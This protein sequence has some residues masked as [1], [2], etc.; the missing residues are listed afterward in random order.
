MVKKIVT[1]ILLE[2]LVITCLKSTGISALV[3][4]TTL[5]LLPCDLPENTLAPTNVIPKNVLA[6]KKYF[7]R[8]IIIPCEI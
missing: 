1:K 3:I 4:E 7:Q 6:P 2:M 5:D 8:E